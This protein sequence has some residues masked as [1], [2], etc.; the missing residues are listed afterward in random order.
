MNRYAI[1]QFSQVRKKGWDAGK[2][3]NTFLKK[4][5]VLLFSL[6]MIS[7]FFQLRSGGLSCCQH[8]RIYLQAI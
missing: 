8:L 3:A 5:S 4:R 6:V 2:C 1:S 7:L